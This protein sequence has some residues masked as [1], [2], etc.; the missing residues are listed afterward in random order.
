[1]TVEQFSKIK[2]VLDDPLA[3][4]RQQR[5]EHDRRVI[6]TF[7]PDVPEELI[8]ASGALPFTLLGGR[9]GSGVAGSIPS[10]ACSLIT[11]TFNQ[12]Y[13]KELEFLDGVVIPFFC[14][15]SRALFQ[16]WGRNFPSQFSDLIRFPK[17]LTSQ[18]TKAYLFK[19]LKRFKETLEN[20]FGGYI[21]NE[22]IWKSIESYNENRK[23]LRKIKG[24]RSQNSHF[25]NNFDFFSLVKSSMFM[26]KGEHN[27]I[28]KEV[29]P[30]IKYSH[31]NPAPQS[32][33]KVFLSGMFVEPLEIFQW[34]DEIGILVVD[35]DLAV[36]SRYF[37]YEVEGADDALDALTESYFKR[38]PNALMEGT[39]N[40]L[41]YISG[42]VR[43]NNLRGVIFVQTKF[44]EPLI[45]DYPDLKKGL[46]REGTPSLLIEKIG[47]AHV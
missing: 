26:P 34:M 6:G 15:S 1:M 32:P 22:A 17:K 46:D 18:G 42:R 19:E 27:R 37:S 44:C 3:Y 21:S 10:F 25:M 38:I 2:K 40:R 30:S 45:Y 11:E 33:I 9:K 4:A 23:Y 31:Q 41:S 47:R 5:L 36:G 7:L 35:D 29:L 20:A 39:E 14:D 8:D 43:E 24:L 28:L 13:F 12:A 16:I